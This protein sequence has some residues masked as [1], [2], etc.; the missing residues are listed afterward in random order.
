[1]IFAFNLLGVDVDAQVHLSD[2]VLFGSGIYAYVK[3][4]I[5]ARDIIRDMRRDIGTKNPREGLLGDVEGLKDHA[6]D[7]RDWLIRAGL[8]QPEHG[9]RRRD[10]QT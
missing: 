10:V 4:L 5:I 7:H 8:D 3:M 9:D 6:A 1:M 2:I